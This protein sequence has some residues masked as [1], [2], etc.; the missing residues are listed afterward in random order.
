M[1]GFLF[2]VI[3]KY[4]RMEIKN[5]PAL[6]VHV[7]SLSVLGLSIVGGMDY[8]RLIFLG[9]PY[10]IVSILLSRPRTNEFL[11]VWVMSIL[12]S[13]FWIEMPVI[14]LG[15]NPYYLWMPESADTRH[16]VIWTTAMILSFGIF[17][18]LKKYLSRRAQP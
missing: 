3:K 6:T 5:N 17:L 18:S 9:F 15:L 7:L 1:G 14:S 4:R 8:T 2:L 12:L 10:Q 11:M 16:L 13:R